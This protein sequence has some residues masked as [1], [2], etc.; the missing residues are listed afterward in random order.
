M[1]SLSHGLSK[2]PLST[3]LVQNLFTWLIWEFKKKR[4]TLCREYFFLP[5]LILSIWSWRF[6][7]IHCFR[8]ALPL[9]NVKTKPLNALIEIYCCIIVR[10]ETSWIWFAT[11]SLWKFTQMLLTEHR[12]LSES[13]W[14]LTKS[15]YAQL[16]HGLFHF[17]RVI[18]CSQ[19][20]ETQQ[21]SIFLFRSI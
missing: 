17:L 7:R 21:V 20:L 15:L 5:C 16:A 19:T 11:A 18:P 14:D 2:V 3:L 10:T 8:I 1:Q 6:R 9:P 4:L 13:K 12:F